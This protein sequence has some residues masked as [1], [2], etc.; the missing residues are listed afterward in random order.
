MAAHRKPK[1]YPLTGTTARTALTLALAGAASTTAFEGASV[2]EPRLTPAQV[3]AEV[4]KLYQEAEVATEK[5]NDAGEKA[6][7]ARR[8]VDN[9]QDEAARKTDDL[10]D[11]RTTL[12]SAATAQ[13]RNGSVAPALQLA[14]ASDPD[15]YLERASIADRAGLRQAATITGVQKQLR[16]IDRLR[17][18][19]DGRLKELRARQADLKRHKS[20][21]TTKLD[22]AERLLGKLTAEQRVRV[23]EPPAA[24]PTDLPQ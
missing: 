1:Q 14:L 16:D 8:E 2:A 7:E 24:A 11:A 10:N 15:D 3:K 13:Y 9:L 22:K 19:A 20:T 17:T 4:D 23:T 18:K 6:K 12:G 21:I 5:Y